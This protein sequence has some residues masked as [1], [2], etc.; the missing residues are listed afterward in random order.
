MKKVESRENSSGQRAD[1]RALAEI[2]DLIDDGVFEAASVLA[3]E[4]QR[5]TPG[6][7]AVWLLLTRIDYLRERYAAAMYAARMATRLDP[8]S[9]VAWLWLARTAVTRARWR[10]EG[11]DAALQ[12]T[13]L[14]PA[15]PD[16]W[17][18]LAQ[19]HLSRDARYEAAIA[20]ERAVRVGPANIEA[21]RTLGLI[22]IQAG[23][24]THAA[25]AFRRVLQL[26]AHDAGARSGL[27]E[28]LRAQHIDPADELA[29]Y[30]PVPAGGAGLGGRVRQLAKENLDLSDPGPMRARPQ[31]LLVGVALC[32]ALGAVIGVVV[33]GLGVVRGLVG[34]F[35]VALMWVAVW[36]LRTRQPAPVDVAA[37]TAAIRSLAN[38]ASVD[39]PAPARRADP[40]AQP[41]PEPRG[42]DPAAH[43]EPEPRRP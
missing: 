22:A 29:G 6:D 38:D 25:A 23:E 24:W 34:A 2:N 1:R 39:P 26:D 28:A 14:A 31:G 5:E 43:A 30:G 11:L 40:A 10:T 16:T 42:A 12:A 36:P 32:L 19:L 18:A 7:P 13:A 4:V 9:S 20:A 35:A 3:W 8:S 37:S 27:A 17:T 15:D 41:D 21:H 33:P